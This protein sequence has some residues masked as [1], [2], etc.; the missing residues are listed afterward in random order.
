[1]ARE[2]AH[3]GQKQIRFAADFWRGRT[4]TV[5]ANI[6][7]A[8]DFSPDTSS[9]LQRKQYGLSKKVPVYD[10]LFRCSDGYAQADKCEERFVAQG[11]LERRLP[12]WATTQNQTG[13]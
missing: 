9:R 7:T 1:M 6:Y 8:T 4:P 3:C 10:C 12:L 2:I 11:F 13:F 5:W